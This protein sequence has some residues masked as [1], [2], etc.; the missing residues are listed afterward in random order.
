MTAIGPSGFKLEIHR[1]E[2]EALGSLSMGDEAPRNA[3]AYHGAGRYLYAVRDASALPASLAHGTSV[4]WTF[5]TDNPSNQS[6]SPTN[7]RGILVLIAQSGASTDQITG[8]TYGGVALT[9]INSTTSPGPGE[10]GRVYVYFLGAGI[11][12]GTQTIAIAN[13]GANTKHATAVAVTG[14]RNA[15]ILNV[16]TLSSNSL[17]NPTIALGPNSTP[18]RALLYSVLYSGQDSPSSITATEDIGQLSEHDHGS[19]SSRCDRLLEPVEYLGTIGYVSSADDVAMV[20]VAVEEET[21]GGDLEIY[22]LQDPSSPSFVGVVDDLRGLVGNAAKHGLEFDSSG[23]YLYV[24]DGDKTLYTLDVSAPASPSLVDTLGLSGID[25]FRNVINRV[26]DTLYIQ[27]SGLGAARIDEVDITTPDAPSAS[28][29]LSPT[30]LPVLPSTGFVTPDSLWILY[31]GN[32]KIAIIDIDGTMSEATALDLPTVGSGGPQVEPGDYIAFLPYVVS[33]LEYGA[34]ILARYEDADGQMRY[35]WMFLSAEGTSSWDDLAVASHDGSTIDPDVISSDFLELGAAAGRTR[36][37]KS[38]I[39]AELVRGVRGESYIYVASYNEDGLTAGRLATYEFTN[40]NLSLDS[41]VGRKLP[42]LLTSVA[43]PGNE[44]GLLTR[45]SAS[46]SLAGANLGADGDYYVATFD[47]PVGWVDISGYSPKL[48]GYQLRYGINGFGPSDRVATS[49]EL[50]FQLNNHDPLGL[51][52]PDNANLLAGFRIGR[53]I[54]WGVTYDASTRYLFWGSIHTVT[55]RSGK[56][57]DRKVEVVCVDFFRAISRS[58]ARGLDVK[59]E[60][61]AAQAAAVALNTMKTDPPAFYA[62][63]DSGAVDTYPV[64][65]DTTRGESTMVSGELD[66]IAATERGY[67]YEESGALYFEGRGVRASRLDAG[68]V[69]TITD[70]HL[71]GVRPEHTVDN[72]I[73]RATGQVFPRRFD[74]SNIVLFNLERVQAIPRGT[75]FEFQ[76]RYRDPAQKAS[77]VGGFD[78][79]EP[80]AGVDYTFNTAEDGSGTDITDFLVV[81]VIKDGNSALVKVENRLGTSQAADGYLTSFQI[82]GKGIYSY[83]PVSRE[84]VNELSEE[85]YGTSEERYDLPYHPDPEIADDAAQYIVHKYGE[86]ASFI[87]EFHVN[88]NY[89]DAHMVAVLDTL[90]LGAYVTVSETVLG[91]SAAGYFIQSIEISVEDLILSARYSVVPGD[92]DSIFKFGP[93]G[94]VFDGPDVLGSSFV[95]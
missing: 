12:T 87:R 57:G 6:F 21:S 76:A 8:V 73:N 95:A 74:T 44:Q 11:P 30:S 59:F 42:R 64:V 84:R 53:E 56:T 78:V 79:Q 10:P 48:P 77:R 63:N 36:V 37:S 46:T 70:A 88:G 93:G 14:N 72:I 20:V 65:F 26:G 62:L 38:P 15:F 35:F 43:M 3:L 91:L 86:P 81:T 16:D 34:T 13:S 9:R 22:D 39:T 23:D 28:S 92:T 25:G 31:P 5:T 41:G 83:E 4:D 75:V 33:S 50:T 61:T 40:L 90:K 51:F 2:A 82:K 7:P 47:E 45:S 55:P 17:A 24:P 18:G 32:G 52:S 1:S 60:I 19:Q 68:A 94:S 66:K 58:K 49:G 27:R 69:F 54:R 71:L 89:S 29:S 80:V 67:M 85:Q